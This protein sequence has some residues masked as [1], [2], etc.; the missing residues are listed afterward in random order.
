MMRMDTKLDLQRF[1]AGAESAVPGENDTPGTIGQE[2]ESAAGTHGSSQPSFEA[3]LK[4]NPEYKAA[5]DARIKRA[6]EARFR[7]MK[8][9]ESQQEQMVPLLTALARRYG[10]PWEQGQDTTPLLEALTADSPRL[11][12][13]ERKQQLRDQVTAIRK[14]HPEFHLGRETRNPIFRALT[15]RG[16]PL[17]AAYALTHQR[18]NTARAM[19]YAISRTRQAIADQMGASMGRPQENGLDS[20]IS[21]QAATDPRAM[22]PGERQS[23]RDRVA[24]GEKVYW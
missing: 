9:L 8:G 20:R 7:Q 17:F 5:Y 21:P 24:R 2:S 22:S 10:L 12:R 11:S 6:I 13:E 14:R 4:E 18:E 19:A 3:L 15:A 23:L 16:V 1:T